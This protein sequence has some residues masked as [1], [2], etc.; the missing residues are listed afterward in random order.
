MRKTLV[1]TQLKELGKILRI[2]LRGFVNPHPDTRTH[3]FATKE[4]SW[5]N[6]VENVMSTHCQRC[7]NLINHLGIEM[8]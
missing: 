8:A 1:A 5:I 3:A 6:N 7:R 2:S 4:L